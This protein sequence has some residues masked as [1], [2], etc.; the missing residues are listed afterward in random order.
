MA[1]ANVERIQKLGFTLSQLAAVCGPD[2]D[3]PTL[4][5][6]IEVAVGADPGLPFLSDLFDVAVKA[7]KSLVSKLQT[8][9][10]YQSEA[11][12]CMHSFLRRVKLRHRF[13]C[14][15]ALPTAHRLG[16]HK[17]AK[18]PHLRFMNKPASPTGKHT[19]LR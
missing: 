19:A 7:A 13:A 15:H 18:H 14:P 3:V 8:E 6:L 1:A 17:H 12:V 4:S 2:S 10:T 11:S 16:A 9:S 5:K